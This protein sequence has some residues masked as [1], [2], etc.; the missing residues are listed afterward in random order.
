MAAVAT[1]GQR[2]LGPCNSGWT[3][4]GQGER[5]AGLIP[6]V[7]AQPKGVERPPTTT[8]Y[9]RQSKFRGHYQEG[10]KRETARRHLNIGRKV[11]RG[12]KQ[13]PETSTCAMGGLPLREAW[14]WASATPS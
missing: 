6:R 11:S 10:V 4:E 13:E 8:A 5:E 1:L 12:F 7:W 2:G 9:P 14:R 3:V